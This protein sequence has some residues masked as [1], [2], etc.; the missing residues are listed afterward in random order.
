[1]ASAGCW[2][3]VTRATPA[4][5]IHNVTLRIPAATAAFSTTPAA[6][7]GGPV[8]KKVN[9]AGVAHAKAREKAMKERGG[10]SLKIKKKPPPKPT[11][12]PPA[13]GERKAMRKRIILSNSNAL[14]VEGLQ[15]M[16]EKILVDEKMVGKVVGLPNEVVDQLRASE[17]FKITQPWGL[18]RRPAV[19]LRKESVMLSKML[20]EA[21]NEKSTK[22]LVVDGDRATGKSMV[23]LHAMA[24]AF[25][26]GWV[27][28][29][30]P[31]AQDIVS[32]TTE[33]APIPNTKPMLFSQN[34][35]TAEWLAR[36]AKANQKVLD[37][38]QLSQKHDLPI[39]VQ[40][41]I[42]LTRLCELGARDPEIAWPMFQAFWAEITA[43]GRPPVLMTLD[44]MQHIM[45]NSA[46]RNADYEII[47][48]HDLAVINHFIQYLSGEKAM[49]N[50][51]AV[52]AATSRSHAPVSQS[53]NLAIVQQLQRQMG[54]EEVAKRDPYEKK[55]DAR[56]DKALQK[57]EVML[58]QGLSKE[59]ARGLME[60]WAASGVLR[61]RVDE[62]TVAEKWALAG[63]GVVGE[64]Q[65]GAL[66]TRI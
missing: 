55:Y 29:T 25:V 41:N 18:F 57:M 15:D 5:L 2:K 36:T 1:M 51:G 32:A 44:G 23:L 40:S 17:A 59:E 61:Q 3:C 56:A 27:V 42:S 8:K 26:K 49:P 50:G 11:G 65:R 48:S 58:L 62:K 66:M 19:L 24:T 10:K 45:S 54:S 46:Y 4:Q 34:T 16:D 14:E 47:H 30:L 20:E 28:L 53:T 35:Y 21:A 6:L 22:R 38:L 52:M 43:A 7:K 9:P 60:Y 33:Y 13:A 39:P 12:K 63:H 37:L 64:I 31:E